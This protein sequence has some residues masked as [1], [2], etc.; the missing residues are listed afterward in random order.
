MNWPGIVFALT[1]PSVV[2]AIV[3]VPFWLRDKA[4]IGNAIAAGVLMLSAVL[5]A[6]HE[7]VLALRLQN[8]CLDRGMFCH[9][10]VPQLF[11]RMAVYAIIAFVEIAVLFLVSARVER[12]RSRRH[13]D[14][15]WR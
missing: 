3:A 13:V 15:Q 12:R 8:D 11:D 14:P 6:N 7:R 9:F 2:A 10:D 4:I 5:L 1:T